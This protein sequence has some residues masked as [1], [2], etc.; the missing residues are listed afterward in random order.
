[1]DKVLKVVINNEKNVKVDYKSK[2]IDILHSNNE[3]LK[4]VL[5][6]R[7]NNEV[8]SLNTV[9]YRNSSIEYIYFDNEDG[10]R[11]YSRTLKFI[12]YMALTKLYKE[13]EVDFISTINKDQF[14]I[15][16]N[17]DL[18]QEKIDIIK[19]KMLE[20][21]SKN[22]PIEKKVVPIEEAR[23][24]YTD[25]NDISKLHNLDNKIRSYA[26]MYFCDG[27]YNYLYGMIAPSTGKIKSFDLVKYK[28]GAMLVIPDTLDE[29]MNFKKDIRETRLYDTFIKYNELNKI[30]EVENV[31][32]L[33]TATLDGRINKIMQSSEAIHQRNIVEIVQK[34]EKKQTVK[35]VLIAGPSSSGKTTF[36][37]KLGVDLTLI[38]LNPV[39][40]SMDNY[41]VERSQTPL[42]EDGKYDFERVDALDIELFNLQMNALIN[43]EEIE[44][45]EFNFFEGKKEYKGNFLKLKS[46]DVL[47]I[48]GIHAL[49]P[50]L[51]KF[52]DDDKK[53]RIYIAPIATLNIDNY[54]KVSSTDIRLL[55][56][57]VRDNVTR[58]HNPEKTFELW[59]NVKKGEEK[60]IFPYMENVDEVFNSS[61]VYEAGILKTFAQP[62]LLQ[63]DTS[64]VYYSEARRLYE[65]LNNF[66]PIETTSVPM[67]SIIRE[68][69]GN[70]CFYR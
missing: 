68:F 5:A 57:M 13:A 32:N 23:I 51:T 31:G 62:L 17:F 19:D 7:V 12:L 34:I 46:N 24:L 55:R 42:G 60:N 40:I 20:I 33:N 16:R 45:P 66:L 8:R 54:T 27:L 15:I 14:F 37:Q 49:N 63:V 11:I 9:L 3:D 10:Y 4:D 1:M 69:I 6:V 29:G 50:I 25:S 28:D 48:E 52:A 18:T 65:F 67:D 47:I 44:I 43:G 39:T 59:K 41:F 64:S 21:I 35:M 53:F 70:G 26:S 22:M 61:L 36:A 38:G 56:R 58:G 2:V 30:L